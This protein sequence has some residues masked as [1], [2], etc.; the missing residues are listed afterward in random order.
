[1]L[2]VLPLAGG[3]GGDA[4]AE[5]PAGGGGCGAV[6]SLQARR[7]RVLAGIW[8]ARGGKPRETRHLSFLFFSKTH[9]G[10]D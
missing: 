7:A 5:Y 10:L 1:M 4:D 9:V 8:G 3:S 2:V 6:N